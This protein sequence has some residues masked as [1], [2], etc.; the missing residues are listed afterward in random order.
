MITAPVRSCCVV[1]LMLVVGCAHR[2]EFRAV[3]DSS[4]AVLSDVRV[5][6]EE[7]GS[8]SYFYR[9]RHIRDAG[10]AD[11]NGVRVVNGV[12]PKNSIFF[13]AAGYHPALVVLDGNDRI[14]VSWYLSP[15]SHLSDSPPRGPWTPS[16]LVVTNI[17]GIITVP[18]VPVVSDK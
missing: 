7:A 3:D 1:A 10:S 4:G 8:F 16:G 9:T 5:R 15:K 2:L 11:T 12:R 18:L 14:R 17:E 13:D 6:V